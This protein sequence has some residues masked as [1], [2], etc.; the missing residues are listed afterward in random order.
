MRVRVRERAQGADGGH[1][2]EQAGERAAGHAGRA[3]ERRDLFE[4]DAHQR[5]P[6]GGGDGGRRR[7]R[8]LCLV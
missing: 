1:R 2:A 6:A 5:E 7:R 3:G 8:R 4:G